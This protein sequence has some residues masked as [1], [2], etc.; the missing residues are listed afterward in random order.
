MLS[1]AAESNA[2]TY[3]EHY[4][5]SKSSPKFSQHPCKIGW[6]FSFESEGAVRDIVQQALPEQVVEASYAAV[7]TWATHILKVL[8]LLHSTVCGQCAQLS[9]DHE[10]CHHKHTMSTP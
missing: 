3:L 10:D 4:G 1:H 2:R 8:S 9:G 6:H 5:P 7:D